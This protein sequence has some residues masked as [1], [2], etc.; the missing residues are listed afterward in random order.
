MRIATILFA[1][2]VTLQLAASQA[3]AETNWR[4]Y[5]PIGGV[6]LNYYCQK[7]YGNEFK[8]VLVGAT[9]GD[10]TC[11]RNN[12]DRREISVDQACGLQYNKYGVKARA[13]DWNNPLSWMCMQ[14]RSSY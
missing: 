9:A 3:L 13:Y 14:P 5:R 6:N 10:W 12:N 2:T 4:R 7:T 8:S 11:Q 1:V